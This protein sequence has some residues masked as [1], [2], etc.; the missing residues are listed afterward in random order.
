MTQLVSAS[1]SQPS[2]EAM[3]MSAF[4]GLALFLTLVGVY[5]VLSFQV[6]RRTHEIGVRLALGA[7]PETSRGSSSATRLS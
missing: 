1:V 7:T 3:L 4:G 2:F 5:G 6:R